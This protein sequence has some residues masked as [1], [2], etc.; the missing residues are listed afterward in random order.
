VER[1]NISSNNLVPAGYKSACGDG[2]PRALSLRPYQR[3]GIE[4]LRAN[5][6]CGVLFW[7][8]R[9]GKTLTTIRFLSHRRDAQ[10]ILV[11]APYSA[12]AGWKKDLKENKKDIYLIYEI[13]P[14]KR[15][16]LLDHFE[17][18]NGWFLLNKEAFLYLDFLSISWDAIICDETWLANP[19][20][21]ITKYFLKNTKARYRI[22]LTGTPAPETELQ[23]Y[24]QLTWVNPAILGCKSYWDFRVRYFRPEGFDW[25]MS[26]KGKT[27]L[28]KRLASYC[29]VL[30]RKDA[31]L[32]KEKIFRNRVIQLTP[33]TR[34]KYKQVESA[35]YDGKIL[36]FAGQRWNECRRLC[37][38][39]EKEAELL[40]LLA[41]ELKE[42]KVMIWADF[43][44]EVERIANILD[45]FYIHG[46]VPANEREEIRMTFLHEK[47]HL[48]AQPQTWKWGTNLSGVDTVIFFSLPQSLMTWQQVCERTVDLE[49]DD[50]L[51]IIT[52]T[53]ENTVEEDIRKSLENKETRVNQIDRLRRSIKGR[54]DEKEI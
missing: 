35:L 8:M 54:R 40:S 47:R 41:G 39:A 49:K 53:A 3:D 32:D 16:Q 22:L 24:T 23:Y 17:K 34:K 27:F 14:K 15:V 19:L 5:G 2:S 31:G 30:T 38:G 37:S 21:K 43:V 18:M 52:L 7:E 29:S 1:N 33:A 11:L 46:A 51:L 26:L 48:V 10:R 28:A 36:K 50:S 44:E 6:G 9:L 42:S 20:S 13:N 45:C 12:L 4:Y 25:V